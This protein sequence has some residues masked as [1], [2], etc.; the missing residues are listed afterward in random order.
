M[1]KLL[2]LSSFLNLV[3]NILS[4][5]KSLVG[6]AIIGT[7]VFFGYLLYSNGLNIELAV[8]DVTAFWLSMWEWAMRG[9]AWVVAVMP[10]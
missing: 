2:A 6:V 8:G 7:L 5:L 10:F 4:N 3:I 1:F 9:W